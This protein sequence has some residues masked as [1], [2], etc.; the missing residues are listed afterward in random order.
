MQQRTDD[1]HT[2]RRGKFTGSEIWKLMVEPR[3]KT[4]TFSETAKTYILEKI[5][6]ENSL[7][8]E[9]MAEF[10]AASLQWGIDNEPKAKEYYEKLTGNKVMEV[11]FIQLEN[12]EHYCGG[13]PDGLINYESI[14]EIKCP[15]SQPNHIKHILIPEDRVKSELREYYWQMQFYMACYEEVKHCEFISFDPRITRDWR[16]HIKTIQRNDEDIQLMLSKIKMAIEY[17]QEVVE[18]LKSNQSMAIMP[19]NK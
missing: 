4:E 14:I 12:F 9:P 17:R 10:L 2:I 7:N 13:S 8:D 18:I 15:F 11:G 3:T 19:K 6:E 16:M 1:W 5:A